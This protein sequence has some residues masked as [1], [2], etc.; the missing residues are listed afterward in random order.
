MKKNIHIAIASVTVYTDRALVTRKNTISLTGDEKELIISNLPITLLQDSVRV[1]GKGTSKINILGVK[2]ESVFT[3]EVPVESIAEIDREIQTLQNQ[4][5]SL[6][7]QL[8]SRQLQI[9][10]IEQLSEKSKTSYAINLSKQETNLEQ[11]EAL[12]KFI[13]DK[14][15][16]YGESITELQQQQKELNDQIA[17]L[18]RKTESLLI[19][20]DKEYFNL[21]IFIEASEPG[22]LE[23]EVSYI[24]N[25]ASWQPLYDL[26]V[27]TAEK[28]LNLTYLAEIQQSTGEDWQNVALTLSTAKPGLG[29]LPPKVEPWY[30]DANIPVTKTSLKARRKIDRVIPDNQLPVAASASM[31][32]EKEQ[33]ESYREKIEVVAATVAKSGSVVTFEVNGGGNIPSDGTPHKVTVFSDRYPVKL[34]HVAIPRLVS[35]VYLQAVVT[36]PATGVTL[37]PGKANILREQTFVGTTHLENI[38]PSQEFTLNLGIDEG[39]KIER[40]LVQR[41]V[42][43]KLIGGNKRITYAYRLI[44]NNLQARESNLKLIEQLPVS[45]NEQIKVRLLQTEPKIKLGE[46]GVMEWNLTL[47]EGNKQEINYQFT[48]EY[49]PEVSIYGLNI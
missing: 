12:L 19:P 2:V 20:Q 31:I 7:N 45:R 17:A 10:F 14:H 42:D 41:Q 5:K 37:L 38:A 21:I 4:Q 18:E 3:P 39:W 43:K 49:P 8:S 13:G 44:V 33:T 36:N 48:L 32:E 29:T 25:R 6:K 23:L 22:E 11:T 26:K 16:A 24:V 30:I 27:D 34:E 35:F 9:N 28:Q 40:N 47:A 1:S 46:I 15:L